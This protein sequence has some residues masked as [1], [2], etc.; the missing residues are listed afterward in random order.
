MRALLLEELSLSEKI[1]RAGSEVVPRF[2]MLGHDAEF[3]IFLPLPN[4]LDRR[5]QGLG[6]IRQFM[7][8]KSATGVVMSVETWLGQRAAGQQAP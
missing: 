5:V 6:Y 1:V 8:W 2:R 4:D 7:A 3:T